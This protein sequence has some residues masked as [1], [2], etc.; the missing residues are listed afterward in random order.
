MIART[1]N[2]LFGLV[3][4]LA[5]CDDVAYIDRI[6]VENATDYTADV[7][8][9]GETGGWLALIRVSAHETREIEQVVD[10]G[11]MWTF[12][13]S[14]GK[15]DPVELEMSKDELRDGGWRIEVPDELEE[16]LRAE[17]VSPP[18]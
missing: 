6:V 2:V 4:L 18:P 7:A 5:A 13:F 12:R 8:V 1:R 16:R 10:Q 11:S 17:G 15:Y 9:R 3:M 14:Y